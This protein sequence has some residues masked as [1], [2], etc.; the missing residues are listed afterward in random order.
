MKRE[1]KNAIP[2]LKRLRKVSGKTPTH[3]CD[4]CSCTRYSP[5]TCMRKKG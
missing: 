3:K 4:N 1:D 2:G 5:C